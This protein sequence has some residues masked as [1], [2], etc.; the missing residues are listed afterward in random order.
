VVVSGYLFPTEKGGGEF[1]R[2]DPGR[3]PEALTVITAILD[4]IRD[5]VFVPLEDKCRFCDFAPL[6]GSGVKARRQALEAAS[7]PSLARLQEVL[8]HE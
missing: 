8:D 3:V 4:L 7:D 1:F 5:G 2:R 6:C